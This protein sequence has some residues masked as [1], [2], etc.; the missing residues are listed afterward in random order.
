MPVYL[1]VTL[2]DCGHLVQQELEIGTCYLHAKVDPDHN[3]NDPEFYCG[4]P[5][6]CGEALW[7]Q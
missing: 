3:I 4:K 7:Q 5:L 1:Y 6:G 2:V